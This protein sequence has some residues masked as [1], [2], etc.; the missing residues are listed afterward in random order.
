MTFV[1]GRL[2]VT[3]PAALVT[4][5]TSSYSAS[6]N[7][8]AGSFTLLRQEPQR[9]MSVIGP[10]LVQIKS[11]ASTQGP[12]SQTS[13]PRSIFGGWTNFTFP[14][15]GHGGCGGGFCRVVKA[16]AKSSPRCGSCGSNN[17]FQ[18]DTVPPE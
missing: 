11:S 7:V 6:Q 9:W 17:V 5:G 4:A 2:G 18:S 16:K 3:P 15:S 1:P 12:L 14:F 13:K 10:V 8:G